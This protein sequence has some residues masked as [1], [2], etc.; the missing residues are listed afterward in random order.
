ML[1]DSNGIQKILPHRYPFLLVDAIE[2]MEPM[3]AHCGN[4]ERHHQ[5]KFLSGPF[6]RKADHAGRADHRIHGADGGLL[7]LQEVRGPR[8][9]AALFRLALITRASA[10][11]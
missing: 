1:L 7:L 6:S 2:E 11:R 5:R 8:E 10:A 9:K 3:E 4:Q